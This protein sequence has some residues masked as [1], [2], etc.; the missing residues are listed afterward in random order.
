MKNCFVG[1]VAIFVFLALGAGVGVTHG[2]PLPEQE[3]AARIYEE[4]AHALN[5]VLPAGNFD[6]IPTKSTLTLKDGEGKDVVVYRAIK[7]GKVTGVAFE[8][9]AAGYSGEIRLMMGV[10]AT[11][12]VIGVRV[13]S[14]HE[15]PGRADR[16]DA[17]R[18]DWITKFTGLSL[19]NPPVEQWKI[20]KDGGQFDQFAGATATPRNVVLAVKR[21]LEFF[22]ANKKQLTEVK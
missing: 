15:T 2:Q 7:A 9:Q 17:K 14:H 19:G 4:R 20:K 12:K 6:N 11:G 21:G 22:A 3:A 5:Q 16:I 10:D 1:R 18:S 13:F 8:M